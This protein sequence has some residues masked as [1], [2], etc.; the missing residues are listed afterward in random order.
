MTM[1]LVQLPLY[2]SADEALTLIDFLGQLQE[3]LG[4]HY[5]DAI[6]QA[7]PAHATGREPDPDDPLPF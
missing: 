2:L 4:D 6:R 3:L 1:K 5:G 7:H